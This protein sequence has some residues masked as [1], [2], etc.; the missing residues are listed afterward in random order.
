M[1]KSSGGVVKAVRAI[2]EPLAEQLG[3]FLWDVEYVKEG[4]DMYLRITIDSEEGIY[5]EDC[6]KMHRAIDPLLDEADP[7][8]GAYHLEVSSPGI[9]RE[10]KTDLHIEACLGWDVE[11]KLYAPVDG[12]KS[13]FGVLEGIDEEG[14]VV[15][16]ESDSEDSL[17]RF[18]RASV[19]SLRTHFSFEEA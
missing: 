12:T 16:S 10:L 5:I 8:E 13:F 6:E 19:A 7:I 4:A 17:R 14:N 15:I 11:V 3:Y 9:E 2:A 18:P 1:K